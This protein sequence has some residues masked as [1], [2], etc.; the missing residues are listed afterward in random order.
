[1]FKAHAR[2]VKGA[3]LVMRGLCFN[4]SWRS[5][6]AFVLINIGTLMQGCSTKFLVGIDGSGPAVRAEA[7]KADAR[8]A[9]L[10][11]RVREALNLPS[12]HRVSM[13]EVVRCPPE[14]PRP[15]HFMP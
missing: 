8:L 7:Q 14:K 4:L 2:R 15:I 10:D 1:M 5:F 9:Q 12:D 11:A 6:I 3:R 13:M